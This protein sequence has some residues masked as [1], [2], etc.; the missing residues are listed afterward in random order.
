MKMKKSLLAILAMSSVAS[1]AHADIDLFN[2]NNAKI[3]LFGVLDAAAG[4]VQ[5][6]S[7]IDS[8]FSASV[9]PYSAIPSQV[10]GGASGL[11]N[12][13]IS[14][15][16]LGFKGDMGLGEGAVKAFFVLETGFNVT[17]MRLNNG[18]GALA[19]NGGLAKNALNSNPANTS[20]NGELFNRQ[21]NAG[22]S[23]GNLGSVAVGRNYAPIF[24]IALVYD[25]VQDAQLFSPLGFSGGVGG[26]GGISEDTRVDRSVKYSNKLGA[27][28]FG[29]LVKQ[30]T[31]AGDTAAKSG[32]G[33]DAGYDDGAF[34]VQAAYQAFDDALIGAVGSLPNSVAVTAYDTKAYM[35]GAKYKINDAATVKI[36]YESYTFGAASDTI[37]AA[38]FNYYSQSISSTSSYS[39]ADKTTHTIWIGG[40]Y[41]FTEKFNL[42]AGI[43]DISLQQSADFI[44]ANAKGKEVGQGSGDQRYYS[45]LADY[46]FTKTFD[47][48]G[49]VMVSKFSG[50]QYPSV[51]TGGIAG[52]YQSNNIT[53]VGVRF[54]F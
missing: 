31:T 33:L 19:S 40:D 29:A 7:G 25:P 45:L 44:A 48:Y 26:G 10:T 22:I 2:N 46:H 24:D 23:D 38:A 4:N 11:F 43:Y 51:T 47:A 35:L 20:L 6:Q 28:N 30:T 1:V 39:G 8:Q 21:A 17:T 53:A 13:G 14:D 16:R 54:K 41:N 9:N 49:G 42:A 52:V 15:S 5:H 36:G 12:G 32:Y 18:A 27:F 37:A 3:Q 34:G 50:T